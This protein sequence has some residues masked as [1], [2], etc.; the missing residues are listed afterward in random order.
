[1]SERQITLEVLRYRPELDDEPVI[2]SYIV[3]VQEEWVVLDVLNYIKDNIDRTLSYRWSCHMSVCGSCGM[4]INNTPMLSC[5]AFVRDFP[6]TIRVE[7]LHNF[8]IERDLVVVLDDFMK[9][10]TVVKPYLIP[11][12]PVAEV[13]G[14][15]KQTSGQ[16]KRFK[17]YAM[18]INCLACYSVCPQYA[19]N[20][21]F[22]GPAALALA[23]RYN[24]DSRDQGRSVREDVVASNEGIWECTFVGACSEVCPKHVDPAAAIQQTKIAST[25]D[26]FMDKLLL[27]KKK[28]GG[29]VK[30]VEGGGA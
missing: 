10:M 22:V 1:M 11:K 24:V 30:Q 2:Q 28:S 12:E 20:E 19:L 29:V 25:M 27:G 16:L 6:D 17:P 9:K 3:P 7:P 18:C 4:V 15:Y 8:P 5:K 21:G 26:Y 14:T 23:H 13:D